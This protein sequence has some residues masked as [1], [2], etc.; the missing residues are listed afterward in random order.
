MK[1]LLYSHYFA[2]SI[3]GVETYVELLA[4]GLALHPG[5]R[6]TVVTQ[7]PPGALKDGE[8]FAFEVVRRPGGKL[9]RRIIARADVVHVAGP[10]LLPLI[11]ARLLRKRTIVEHHAYQAVCPNGLLLQQPTGV[12]CP[13][14]YMAKR[15]GRCIRCRA[16][17]RGQLR[18]AV[19]I[20]LTTLRRWLCAGV[21]ANVAVSDHVRKRLAIK[22]TRVIRHGIVLPEHPPLADSRSD[23]PLVF[24]YVGRFVAEKGIG[25]LL[26]AAAALL[27]EGEANFRV[28]LVGDGPLRAELGGGLPA[29]TSRIT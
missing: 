18:G 23:Q 25:L 2:P 8:E 15:Y 5:M 12:N 19:D 13:G 9:L 4:R 28:W 20:P 29:Q 1:I 6:V 26:E 21:G 17:E 27:A 16:H 3:G 7:T 22:G 14:H 24:G 10:A 11:L